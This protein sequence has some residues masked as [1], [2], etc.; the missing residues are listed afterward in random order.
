MNS[1]AFILTTCGTS[2]LTNGIKDENFRRTFL[3]YTNCLNWQE[4][5]ESLHT[6]F[7]Q[8]FDERR[9]QLLAGNEPTAKIMSAE[10]NGLITWQE[11][12][13]ASSRNIYYLLATDTLFGQTTA[14]IIKQWLDKHGFQTQIISQ[15]G[16]RTLN[17]LEFRGALS[18][19]V[20]QLIQTI[21]GYKDNGFEIYFNLT[22]G[23]K[24]LNGF[25]QS[26]STI[27]ADKT[28]YLFEG[29]DSELLYIPK[30][31]YTLN[32]KAFIEEHMLCFRRFEQNLPVNQ[33]LLDNF[34]NSLLMA[35]GD[36][37]SEWGEIIWLS[38]YKELFKKTIYNSISPQVIFESDFVRSCQDLTAELKIEVN[39]KVAMLAAFVE[40]NCKNNLKS[41][42]A[43][44]LQE[45]QYK[46]ENYW[47]CDVDGKHYRIF[48]RKEGS[49]FYLMQVR[50]AL[51]KAKS[52]I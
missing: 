13:E 38:G 15:S 19:L 36:M 39:K 40:N 24:S 23:F 5:D 33:S 30:L 34:P 46:D 44:P 50:E 29:K 16:L 51:H 31:P 18:G 35:D 17:L 12:N 49:K 21:Q 25:L 52:T 4:I 8:H 1:P 14:Q 43:K 41:L 48:M 7:Q 2:L 26:V 32:T 37:L 10:L 28:F 42:D 47:E 20:E 22:G 3:K 6:Q 11:Q 45:K 27:Y 9:Q